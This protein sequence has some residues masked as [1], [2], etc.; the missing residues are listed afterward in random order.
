MIALQ[1]DADCNYANVLPVWPK[2]RKHFPKVVTLPSAV[3]NAARQSVFPTCVT[4]PKHETRR[5]PNTGTGFDQHQ[6]SWGDGVSPVSYWFQINRSTSAFNLFRANKASRRPR[7]IS[8]RSRSDPSLSLNF[9]SLD[10]KCRE[11]AEFGKPYFSYQQNQAPPSA[12]REES[13]II[14]AT[15]NLEQSAELSRISTS[16]IWKA[17]IVRTCW[18]TSRS[19]VSFSPGSGEVHCK[20]CWTLVAVWEAA[21]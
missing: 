4:I 11:L 12:P 16:G 9:R 1:I 8:W 18:P 15:P 10:T 21:R 6:C 7:D 5:H 14:A 17:V 19:P 13:G 2:T 20:Q 3:F